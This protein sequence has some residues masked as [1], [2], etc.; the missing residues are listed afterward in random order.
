MG[1]VVCSTHRGASSEPIIAEPD[2]IGGLDIKN[3]TGFLLMYSNG[4]SR[5][6]IEATGTTQ[7]HLDL[8]YMAMAE[9]EVQATLSGV[10]QGVVDKVTRK[11]HDA[12]LNVGSVLKRDDIT[13]IVRNFNFPIGS[14][15]ASPTTTAPFNPVS[16]PYSSHTPQGS[17]PPRLQIGSSG[18]MPDSQIPI[19]T[20][21]YIQVDGTSPVDPERSPFSHIVGD[22]TL[23]LGCINRTLGRILTTRPAP[24]WPHTMSGSQAR[25]TQITQGH[26]A[27]LAPT[28]RAV[29]RTP[30][31][32]ACLISTLVTRAK[33]SL[34]KMAWLILT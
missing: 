18:K 24:L 16:M 17:Q 7:S 34:M 4:L 22:L 13:L 12:Y 5:S 32:S 23:N 29:A 3:I 14:R 26:L 27:A 31:P 15:V 21:L 2:I 25:A 6:L 30:S 28:L 9:F 11:H 1:C 8:A 19:M 10:A 33:Q 20:P